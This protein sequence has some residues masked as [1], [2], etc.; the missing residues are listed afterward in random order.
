MA[1][2]WDLAELDDVS[3]FGR[4]FA[5]RWPSLH[6]SAHNTGTTAPQRT[7]T[8]QV[9]EMTLATHLLAPYLLTELLTET[10]AADGNAPP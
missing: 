5:D 3:R 8:A 9:H 10:L 4:E 2:V 7:E 1:E 6:A